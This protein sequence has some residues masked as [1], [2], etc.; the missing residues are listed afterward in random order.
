MTFME[1][2]LTAVAV[3]GILLAAALSAWRERLDR[4]PRTH[5]QPSA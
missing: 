5:A 3:G 2:L 4:D 1:A